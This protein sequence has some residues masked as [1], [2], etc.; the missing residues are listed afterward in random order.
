MAGYGCKGLRRA[1]RGELE[2]VN[3]SNTFYVILGVAAVFIGTKPLQTK[4]KDGIS[5]DYIKLHLAFEMFHIPNNFFYY[6]AKILFKIAITKQIVG[7]L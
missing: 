1:C 6:E 7:K 3:S 2:Q 4:Q 5:N